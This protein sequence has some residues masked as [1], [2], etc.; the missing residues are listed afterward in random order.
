MINLKRTIHK[1][2]LQSQ[3][4]RCAHNPISYPVSRGNW[5]S[6]IYIGT[7]SVQY[8]KT[9]LFLTFSHDDAKGDSAR[10]FRSFGTHSFST[11]RLIKQLYSIPSASSTTSC[12]L[13][14]GHG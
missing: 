2:E 1:N 10:A 11:F 7:I 8:T 6:A 12:F 14:L 4:V 9:G 13:S 3:H 5:S